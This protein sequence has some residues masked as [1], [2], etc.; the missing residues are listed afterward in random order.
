MVVVAKWAFGTTVDDEINAIR[1][2]LSLHRAQSYRDSITS[3]AH[4][5]NR[6]IEA[7]IR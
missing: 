6:L 7:S 5:A 1:E 3:P 2:H 4:A